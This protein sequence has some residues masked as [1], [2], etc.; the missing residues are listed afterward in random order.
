MY[1]FI[2]GDVVS[3]TPGE[4]VLRA[5]GVGY[6]LHVSLTTWS[7]LADGARA[8]LFTHFHVRADVQRL[9]GFAGK[10]ERE[11]FL[12]LTTVSSI[13]PEKALKMLSA[14]PLKRLCAAIASA[15]VAALS[16]V[17]GIGK[18]TAERITIELRD[19][20][21]VPAEETALG[22]ATNASQAVA[23]LM[24]LGYSRAESKEA[25]DN[26]LKAL[27]AEAPAEDLIRE[28]LRHA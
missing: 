23:G 18:K 6:L 14:V 8:R 25:V 2:E 11:V 27:G 1:D 26:A 12:L 15:D 28:A 24:T 21:S 22:G 13:G 10:D 17:K 4:V 19:K 9:Y 5:G 3:R 7:A 16:Q 20:I